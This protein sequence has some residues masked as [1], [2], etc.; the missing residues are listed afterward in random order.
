MNPDLLK[1]YLFLALQGWLNI[2]KKV[3]YLSMNLIG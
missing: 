1:K 3:D 2:S